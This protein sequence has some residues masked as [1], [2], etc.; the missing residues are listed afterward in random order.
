MKI[1]FNEVIELLKNPQ[2]KI[3]SI[4]EY[5]K[6]FLGSFF[7]FIVAILNG[8]MTMVIAVKFEEKLNYV[9]WY[10]VSHLNIFLKKLVVISDFQPHVKSIGTIKLLFMGI[11]FYILTQGIFILLL[12]LISKIF[13][14]KQ[15]ITKILTVVGYSKFYLLMGL[16]IG[17]ICALIHPVISIITIVYFFIVSYLFLLLGLGSLFDCRRE[18]IY[19]FPII[20]VITMVASLLLSSRLMMEF[21]YY[22]QQ[23][24]S[25]LKL[26]FLNHI[27]NEVDNI[28][29][30]LL[31]Y[32]KNM[33][34][35]VF[36]KDILRFI[37]DRLLDIIN[38][39]S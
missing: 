35:T 4:N 7:I 25:C 36:I 27:N 12:W 19:T 29:E 30:F 23:L 21:Y 22:A 1:Y 15:P 13:K 14:S 37:A 33:E 39:L 17:G 6:P 38:M 10:I 32:F 31:D 26:S 11:L 5:S 18:Y 34:F 3:K 20:A 2:S 28:M 24:F 16:L 8:V 9:V